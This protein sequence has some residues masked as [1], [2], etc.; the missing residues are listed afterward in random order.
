MERPPVL[1]LNVLS[2]TQELNLNVF[3]SFIPLTNRVLRSTAP[4][5][6]ERLCGRQIAQLSRQRRWGQ[7]KG[8]G[9]VPGLEPGGVRRAA[10]SEPRCVMEAAPTQE[11]LCGLMMTWRDEEAPSSAHLHTVAAILKSLGWVTLLC[12]QIFK[13]LLLISVILY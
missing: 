7:V 13:F 8:L 12:N 1:F 9:P 11:A 2:R 10:G 4:G 6:A 5:P 3:F